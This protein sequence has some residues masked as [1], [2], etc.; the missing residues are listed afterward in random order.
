MK[1]PKNLK[2]CGRTFQI[3]LKEKLQD[4]Y[5]YAG[6]YNSNYQTILLDKDN[7]TEKI[8]QTLFHE[9]T[10]AINYDYLNDKLTEEEVNNLGNGFYQVLKDNNL[11]R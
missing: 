8:E 2:I 1:I 3:I 4:K 6:L 10:H 9:I 11:L 5:S 7:H